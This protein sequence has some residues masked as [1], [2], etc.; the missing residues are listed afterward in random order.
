MMA[1][2]AGRPLLELVKLC[3][4]ANLPVLLLGGHGIGKSM[5]F[6]QAAK[7]LDIDYICRDLSLMEPPDL[8]GLPVRV[9]DVTKYA[10]PSFL[11]L[12][13]KG[14]IVFEEINR[15][16]SYMQAPCLQ[17]LSARTLNDYRL[18]CGWVPAGAVNPADDGYDVRELDPALLS[19]FVRTIV[20][21]DCEEWLAWARKT[22]IHPSIID[23]IERDSSIFS[24]PEINPG[25]RSNLD[26]LA[27]NPRAWTY[28]S[29]LLEAA[30]RTG[31]SLEI[32]RVAISGL[33]GTVRAVAF[34]KTL[35]ADS[36]PLTADQI[37]SN[38]RWR[39]KLRG[40]IAAGRLDLVSGSLLNL[41][42]HLQVRRNFNAAMA[43]R[44]QCKNLGAF[45]ADLP[46]DLCKD[47]EEFFEE[48][49]YAVP[50]VRERA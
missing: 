43:D 41:K 10:Y 16:N 37:L 40:W 24:V 23:Y 44:S 48:R 21:P 50:R 38:S 31:T 6:E 47:A 35:R 17:L 22:G 27:S 30:S 34:L 9:G 11:P 5:L 4:S 45:L 39:T 28:V 13:G 25:S 26:P 33:V 2:K 15:A 1:I 7:E 29:Q 12:D 18:P 19:R 20:V 32:L 36:Q 14:L 42:K 49:Q 46:G 3:Y 8:V